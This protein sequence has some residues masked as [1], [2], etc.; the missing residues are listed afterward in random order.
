MGSARPGSLLV[1]PRTAML[2]RMRHI[3]PL[4]LVLL[5]AAS[6]CSKPAPEQDPEGMPETA[7]ESTPAA[8]GDAVAALRQEIA[9]LRARPEHDAA[10]IEVQH[11][12]VSFRGAPRMTSVTRS[13]EE[14]EQLAADLLRRVR[15]GRAFAKLIEA[16]TNDS[17]PGIYTMTKASRAGMVR[18][19]GDVGWRLQVGE[20]G[21]AGYDATASPFGWHIIKRLK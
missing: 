10:E 16:H 18:A 14:A 12:L 9:A 1:A 20:I 11:L 3:V 15:A 19:F 17:P 4:V 5:A 2:A 6:S 7:R 8:S 21:V 13:L